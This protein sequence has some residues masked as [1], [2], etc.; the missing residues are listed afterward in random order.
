[1]SCEPAARVYRGVTVEAEHRADV[2]VVDADGNLTHYLGNPDAVYMTRS[3]LKPLQA[4]PLILTGGFDRFGFDRRHLAVMCSSHSGTDEH[5]AVVCEALAKAG[6]SPDDLQCGAGWPLYFQFEG[7][8]PPVRDDQFG[9]LRSDCS[10]K[11]AGFLALA[12]HLG[13]PTSEY[14]NPDSR[15]QQ[16]IKQTVADVCEYPVEKIA[17]GIDGCS[18]PNFSLPVKNLAI[19][20]K[21]IA[22]AHGSDESMRRA[23]RRVFEAM[24]TEPYLVAGRN[25]FC[26]DFMRSLPGR[27]VT[28]LGAESIQGLGLTD[29]KIGIAVKVTDGAIRALGPICLRVLR[30]LGIVT[31]LERLPF[32]QPYETPVVRNARGIETGRIV[33]D[34]ALRKV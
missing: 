6:H 23:L 10:G 9:S 16:M 15:A 19:G 30:E 2:A 28:K 25:R 32:L 11:H 8:H 3:S 4:L 12:R 26:Y 14:L 31:N 17:T 22:L 29:P 24:T 1:V 13:E 34:F 5:V 20:F 18:A 7:M 21:N 27:G 33:V